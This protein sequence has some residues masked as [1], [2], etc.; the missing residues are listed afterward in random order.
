MPGAHLNHKN[1]KRTDAGQDI[2]L[3]QEVA[4]KRHWRRKGSRDVPLTTRSCFTTRRLTCGGK[5]DLKNNPRLPP[6][7]ALGGE[8]LAGSRKSL[9]K[10]GASGGEFGVQGDL[11]VGQ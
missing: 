9:R 2:V 1:R 3:H 5:L 4:K 6:P 7:A 8:W 10:L 11:L